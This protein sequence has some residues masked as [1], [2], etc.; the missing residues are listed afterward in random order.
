MLL[1]RTLMS[2]PIDFDEMRSIFHGEI[3]PN[4]VDSYRT[5][6]DPPK[7]FATLEH[8]YVTISSLSFGTKDKL[9]SVNVSN[10]IFECFFQ[11]MN[12]NRLF[13][14]LSA[15]HGPKCYPYF[16][17]WKRVNYINS[18]I[19]CIDDPLQKDLKIG[20]PTWYYGTNDIS[21]L[22]YAL[23]IV[24]VAMREMDIKSENV[25]FLGSSSAG[26]A[27]LYLA[28]LLPGS[29]AIAFNPQIV[30]QNWNEK[31]N[32]FFLKRGIDLKCQDKL[33]RNVLDNLN[34]K[35]IYFIA[36]NCQSKNDYEKHFQ[37]LCSLYDI[38]PYYG[39]KA[40][41][42]FI[43]WIHS[44]NAFDPHAAFPE[45]DLLFIDF[46][47]DQYRK[48]KNINTLSKLSY[49]LNE[50]MNKEYNENDKYLQYKVNSNVTI[51][52]S[53]YK[54]IVD[55][56]GKFMMYDKKNN[57][58]IFADKE[59]NIY[60]YIYIYILNFSSCV[61]YMSRD[62]YLQDFD[63]NI[64]FKKEK[65]EIKFGKKGGIYFKYNNRWLHSNIDGKTSFSEIIK[66]GCSFKLINP[67]V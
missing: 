5:K 35:S 52:S 26:T 25:T 60:I 21:Y 56:Y 62:L 28:S 20:V 49:L 40:Q 19:L 45:I 32:R 50:H 58:I 53:R 59:N 67:D 38:L 65:F 41:K 24:L 63:G 2:N 9:Y 31:T 42:N 3:N 30:L 17:R 13:I 54:A 51:H 18:S 8:K 46:I 33:H 57:K 47:I 4:D 34:S 37:P 6:F 44:T 23:Q 15:I 11:F 61:L 10:V 7:A 48:G 12:N 22:T 66:K 55:A 39:I 1:N 14:N 43:T 27:A 36:V 64:G 16:S 29:A